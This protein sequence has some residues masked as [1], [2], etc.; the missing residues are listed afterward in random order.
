MPDCKLETLVWSAELFANTAVLGP[1]TCVQSTANVPLEPAVLA[2][3]FKVAAVAGRTAK[4][5]LPAL[6]TGNVYGSGP[7]YVKVSLPKFNSPPWN[8]IRST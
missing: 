4:A 2:E 7:V 8:A 3:P 6:A 5:L 1:Y